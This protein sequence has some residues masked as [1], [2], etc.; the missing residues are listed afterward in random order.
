MKRVGGYR[1][2]LTRRRKTIACCGHKSTHCPRQC[3]RYFQCNQVRQRHSKCHPLPSSTD[4][5]HSNSEGWNNACRPDRQRPSS[6]L[7]PC[8][9]GRG[10]SHCKLAA[11]WQWER[12]RG[13]W[14]WRWRASW[15]KEE[16]TLID[17][18]RSGGKQKGG[19]LSASMY[20]CCPLN[21]VQNFSHIALRDTLKSV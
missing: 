16:G 1:Y 14:S 2:F 18:S 8:T 15:I 9:E 4:R 5:T 19:E 10:W 7:F 6:W 17:N 12:Q 21:A 20:Y 11:R 3:N 13:T